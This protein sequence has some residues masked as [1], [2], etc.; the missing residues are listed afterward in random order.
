MQRTELWQ[1]ADAVIKGEPLTIRPST[2]RE[3]TAKN[4]TSRAP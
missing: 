2:A 3:Y 1:Q 4:V